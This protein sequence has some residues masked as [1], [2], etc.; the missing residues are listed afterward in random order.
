MLAVIAAL[1][2]AFVAA[3]PA[4]AQSPECPGGT[5]P[6][7][8]GQSIEISHECHAGSGTYNYNQ[9]NITNGGSLIF[10]EGAN[11]L[12]IAIDFWASSILIENGG[13]LIAG[14]VTDPFGTRGGRLTIHLYGA[15]PAD[16]HGKGITC[17]SP[18]A[19]NGAP[20]G[21]DKDIWASNGASEQS[22]PGGVTDRFYKY[23]PLP[24]DDGADGDGNVGFFGAKVLAVSYGGT[25][26]LFGKK[27]AIYGAEPAPKNSGTSWVRLKGTIL[28][29]KNDHTLVVSSPVDWEDGDHF[30]VTTT[31]YLANH[32]EEMVIEDIDKSGEKIKFDA[33][34]PTGQKCDNSG[35]KWTHNGEQY[36]LA[37]IPARLMFTK[38][39]AETRAA[40]ALLTRS[41]QI[42]SGGAAFGKCFAPCD[43]DPA[44]IYN[45]FGGQ[46]IARAGFAAFNVQGV[47]FRQLGQGGRIGHYPVHFHMAR[48]TPAGTFLKDS[49]IN[50]SMTRWVT[51]HGTQNVLLARNVGY[52]SIGHGFYLEDAVE[53]DNKLYSNIGIFARAA[54]KNAQNPRNIPGIL[55]SPDFVPIPKYMGDVT[56]PSVFWITNGWN[57]FQGNMAAGAALCG[58]CYWQAPAQICGGSL[59][60][61]WDSYAGTQSA[62]RVGTS[63]LMNFDGNFCTSAMTSFQTVGYTEACVGVGPTDTPSTPAVP[64]PNPLAPSTGAVAPPNCGAGT[65][66]PICA[67]DYYPNLDQGQLGHGSKCPATGPCNQETAPICQDADETNCVPTVINDYTTSFNYASYNFA[68]VWLRTRWHLVSNSFISDVQNA[69]LSFISGGDYTHSSAIKGLWELALKTVFVGQT[70]PSTKPYGYASALS[71]FNKETGLTCD[72]SA[73]QT[74]AC[75]SVKNS[76]VMGPF[77]AFSVA[78]HMFN[79]YD[80]PAHQ[81]SNAYID[82]KKID[83]GPKAD[84]DSTV[85]WQVS[86]IPKAVLVDKVNPIAKNR[87]YIPNAAVGWKQ[88]N[89]FYYPPN[90]RSR[91]L[92]FEDVD[93]RHLVIVPQ[94]NPNTYITNPA[95]TAARYCTSNSTTFGEFSSVDR[96]TELTDVDGSLTGFAKTTSVNEDPF[97]TAPIEGVECQS[98]GAVTEGGT[99]RT[100]PYEY[101]TTVVYPEATRHVSPPPPDAGY[102][103]C[104]DTE[105]DSEATNPRQFGVPLYREYQTGSEWLKKATPE[106]IRMAGMNL[107]QRETMTVNNGHYFFDTT[108][109]KTTQTTAPWKPQD[110]RKIG[111]DPPIN[112]GGL[113]SVF[114][115]GQ[116]YD[117]FNVFATEKTAQTYEMYVGP[118]FVVADGFK[119]IRVDV[120]NAPFVISP[121]S[122]NPGSIVPAY[123]PATGILKVTLNLSAYQSDFDGAKRGHCVPQS[124]CSYVGSTCVGAAAPYPP[125]NLTKAERDITCGY[126]GKDIDCPNGGCIGFSVKMPP[127]FVASD[128][129]TAQALPAK[130]AS[131]FPNDA[132]WNVTPLA[133][134][135]PLAGSCF[136]APLVKNFCK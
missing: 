95:Q 123:D 61:T 103:S 130:A 65:K 124:F 26:Q 8:S 116:T 104:G 110:I 6:L 57:D 107:C 42:V 113:I 53:T 75:T 81:D 54:I 112:F 102:L 36:S 83:I 37:S 88:P 46:V 78:Q 96:Q 89:G 71:P 2:G 27:G 43:T 68:A 73:D 59:K 10:D 98:D 135:K 87:C 84:K 79:I 106:F 132:T 121:D 5:L 31:D 4:R 56:T 62:T 47:E 21:I 131:C 117:F 33:L 35:A 109:S 70:Q 60:M 125:S 19:D 3:G 128:Q 101:L 129:T 58:V 40:V 32:S 76:M 34:C 115:A 20:C 41:I 69:G 85:Y 93:I 114:K 91:N 48:K 49:S 118:E 25:L 133:A 126:A 39:A 120:R 16:L 14:S 50:E 9:I 22:L 1:L 64:V 15:M 90:F 12:K 136:N 24:F 111:N 100:S 18:K 55:S 108:A 74:R 28:G 80:G 11:T 94:H 86:G 17:K 127:K 122:S 52:L 30:V 105:W 67:G 97:F 44:D 92:F 77:T 23:D 38:K 45:S 63:P 13:K 66:W 82:I 72:Y 99:A 134:L 29:G 119:R 7:G 51:V